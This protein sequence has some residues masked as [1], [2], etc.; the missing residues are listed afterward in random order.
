MDAAEGIARLRAG[1][2]AGARRCFEAAVAADPAD[3]RARA[4]L[5]YTYLADG[6]PGAARG[7]YEA[8]LRADP[9]LALAHHG[10]A[11]ALERL[12][13]AAGARRH[14]E[15]GLTHRPITALRYAGTGTPIRVLLLGTA[16][17]GNLATRGLLDERTFATYALALEYAA[18]S[19]RLPPHDVVF[20]AVTEA[21][22][23]GA[24]LA[25]AAAVIARTAAPVVNA[26]AAVARTGRAENAARL[27]E[28]PGVVTPRIRAY[29]RVRLEGAGAPERL[30][31]D[32]F[33]FPLL[34][35]SPGYHTGE[36]FARVEAPG[37]LAAIVATLP[38]AELFVLEALDV[39]AADGKVRKYRVIAIGGALYP[40][41]AAISHDWK[42]H[43]FSA[44]MA[45]VA[46]HRAEDAAF[47]NAMPEVL[48]PRAVA[49]LERVAAILG[50]DYAGIDFALDRA[51]DVA[52]FEANASMLVPDPGPDPRWDYRRPAVARIREA[53]R[54][55][56]V[57]RSRAGR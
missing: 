32:G 5:A 29:P 52:V 55:L 8:A 7:H 20:N 41:H 30:A 44:E 14:R 22:A 23:S 15:L 56:V 12:G 43:F 46:A 28:V 25:A 50:L 45:G 21:D 26:P 48:G 42:V 27:R 37:E 2:R 54:A 4:S 10:L 17:A 19:L 18:P 3:A 1:D 38:G 24:A 11:D 13:D 33:V 36:H 31:A 57:A 53:L 40:V 49:A 34:V 47:L 51:G 39:R 9:A 16:A 35:R 6:D